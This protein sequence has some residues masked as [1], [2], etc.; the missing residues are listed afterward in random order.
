MDFGVL[1]HTGQ[2]GNCVAVS[3]SCNNY[4]YINLPWE[5]AGIRIVVPLVI[6]DKM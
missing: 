3:V 4:A 1:L 2:Q 5:K 6:G